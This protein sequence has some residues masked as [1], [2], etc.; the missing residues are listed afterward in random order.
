VDPPRRGLSPEVRRRI[1]ALEP[2][3]L[4]YVSC[5]PESF[6]RDASHL[7]LLGSRLDAALPFDMIPQSD[8]VEVL[9]RFVPG[10][11]P[12]PLILAEGETFLAVAKEPHEPVTS[13]DE[14]PSLT[15]R[16]RRIDGAH[17]ASPIGGL[18]D[19][20]SG[21]CLFA[22]TATGVE[23]LER[24]LAESQSHFTVLARGVTHARGRLAG[25]PPARYERREV[26]AGHSLLTIETQAADP[27]PA[28]RTLAK[29]R[30]PIIG[31]QRHGDRRANVH[32]GHRHQLDRAFVH[33]HALALPPKL[34]GER[35]E[36][37]LPPDL[38][39]VLASLRDRRST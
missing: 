3:C 35:I 34:S 21:V 17:G 24:A 5:F 33:R 20:V 11:P 39:H 16:V 7:A 27:G 14:G 4:L 15:A 9:G 1:A 28:C 30:H 19:G 13:T 2:D 6:A 38:A 29:L 37:P 26:V 8:A 12:P 36:A 31:D 23:A 22:R 10:A 32:F 18:D 25:S